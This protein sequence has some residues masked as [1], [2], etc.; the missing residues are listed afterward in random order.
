MCTHGLNSTRLPMILFAFWLALLA[1]CPRVQADCNMT[2]EDFTRIKQSLGQTNF[3]VEFTSSGDCS[4]NRSTGLQAR[5]GDC[6]D[7]LDSVLNRQGLATTCSTSIKKSLYRENNVLSDTQANLFASKICFTNVKTLVTDVFCDPTE[8]G[9][10]DDWMDVPELTNRSTCAQ[11][12]G[13]PRKLQ[14]GKFAPLVKCLQK[15]ET[16]EQKKEYFAEKLDHVCLNE[17]DF[18]DGF[19]DFSSCEAPMNDIINFMY[20]FTQECSGFFIGAADVSERCNGNLAELY[21][22]YCPTLSFIEQHLVAIAVG[23]PVG[24]IFIILLLFCA[25]RTRSDHIPDGELL[26]DLEE[27]PAYKGSP[28]YSPSEK[29]M[30]PELVAVMEKKSRYKGLAFDPSKLLWIVTKTGETYATE[31]EAARAAYFALA[32]S[33]N[34]GWGSPLI[35]KQS[36]SGALVSS[37]AQ[38]LAAYASSEEVLDRSHEETDEQKRSR[39]IKQLILFYEYWDA[40]RHDIKGHVETLFER[41]DFTYV[42]RAVRTKF[43]I[44][45]PGWDDELEG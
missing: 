5:Y 26:A 12:P 13:C 31:Q 32:K 16:L 14:V 9:D 25:C 21:Q 15:N 43:G 38:P 4:A 23:V 30:H 20:D 2:N 7:T 44:L 6:G 24:L 8:V 19:K 45:P 39:H 17:N 29:L 34:A 3:F 10:E 37:F 28:K 40:D 18:C 36:S 22:R 1:L 42:A 33:K 27:A 35:S 41:H 11:V